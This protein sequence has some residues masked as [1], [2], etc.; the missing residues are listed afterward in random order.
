MLKTILFLILFAIFNQEC[1]SANILKPISSDQTYSLS[2][3]LLIPESKRSE[4]KNL[5]NVNLDELID[6]KKVKAFDFWYKITQEKKCYYEGVVQFNDGSIEYTT[7]NDMIKV[8]TFRHVDLID[9]KLRNGIFYLGNNRSLIQ[10]EH[11]NV[12]YDASLNQPPKKLTLFQNFKKLQN[13]TMDGNY[14]VLQAESPDG[15]PCIVYNPVTNTKHIKRNFY[16]SLQDY[17]YEKYPW[18][19]P[20]F[21]LKN[22]RDIN[23]NQA[24]DLVLFQSTFSCWIS[25]CHKKIFNKVIPFKND[26]GDLI[27]FLQSFDDS[28][29]NYV[30]NVK[31]KKF[32][33]IKKTPEYNEYDINEWFYCV[34]KPCVISL[35]QSLIGYY[36]GAY[37]VILRNWF[38]YCK[39]YFRPSKKTA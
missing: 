38:M 15:K 2:C 6:L 37:L 5:D 36:F 32:Y 26:T 30:F 16:P 31:E 9:S 20:R 18:T 29:V 39:N 22:D 25:A 8:E 7:N 28:N 27:L 12:V 19:D 10:D 1:A 11:G 4:L 13:V 34:D 21:K 14:I 24:G 23:I 33:S 3:N 17:Y 35:K